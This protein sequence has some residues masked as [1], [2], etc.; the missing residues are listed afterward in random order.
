MRVR[1]RA[2]RSASCFV[3][4]SSNA[5]YCSA[6]AAEGRAQCP[7]S[8]RSDAEGGLSPV[9]SVRAIARLWTRALHPGT[10]GHSRYCEYHTV[11][12]HYGLSTQPHT[13]HTSHRSGYHGT[14]RLG[15]QPVTPASARATA[16]AELS[17]CI[18][19]RRSVS[20]AA[21]R[22]AKRHATTRPR[23]GHCDSPAGTVRVLC[24]IE[25]HCRVLLQG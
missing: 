18:E 6:A 12:R 14:V 15:S 20:A 2:C 19:R 10:P 24:G 23:S 25:G 17:I 22:R 4:L 16:N 3:L 13:C 11:G 5:L 7:L 21:Q 1:V 9:L 8:T